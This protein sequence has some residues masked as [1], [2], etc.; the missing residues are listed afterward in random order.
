MAQELRAQLDEVFAARD[1]SNMAPTI[2]AFL[3]VLEQHPGDPEALYE[4]GGAYDTDGQEAEAAGYYQRAIEAG[5]QGKWLR[6]CYLQYGS[7]LRNLGRYP[8]S[9][10]LLDEGLA[11][12]PDSESLKV[13]RALTL[14]AMGSVDA[15]LG[16]MLVLVADRL[17]TDEI[18]R[19]EAAI[20]GNGT[21]LESRDAQE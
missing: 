8:E 17:R 1:R 11:A 14:H 12:F 3:N 5:L 20:R 15:A 21:Y 7:T 9:L 6:Q 2:D 19:Y 16:S 18:L 10:A 13:F 4:V